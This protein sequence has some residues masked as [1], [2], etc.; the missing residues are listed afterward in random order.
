MLKLFETGERT[1]VCEVIF[2]RFHHRS[3]YTRPKIRYRSS[4]HKLDVLIRENVFKRL[5]SPRFRKFFKHYRRF[6]IVRLINQGQ[7][8]AGCNEVGYHSV[9]VPMVKESRSDRTFSLLTNGPLACH[10][11]GV[12]HAGTHVPK[13]PDRS[14]TVPLVAVF[15]VFTFCFS[16]RFCPFSHRR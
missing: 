16:L 13:L 5:H 2:S 4:S 9:N 14:V 11:R 10:H 3:A 6:V 12:M 15:P 1:L 7:T 8:R